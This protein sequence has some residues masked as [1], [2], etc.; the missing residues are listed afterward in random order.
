MSQAVAARKVFAKRTEA[1]L[2]IIFALANRE[3][4]DPLV[5]DARDVVQEIEKAEETP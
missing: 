1:V 4:D 2:D 5:M 3:N